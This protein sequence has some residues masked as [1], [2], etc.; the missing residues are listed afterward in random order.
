MNIRK[1]FGKIKTQFEIMMMIGVK[2]KNVFQ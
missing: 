2:N 1:N